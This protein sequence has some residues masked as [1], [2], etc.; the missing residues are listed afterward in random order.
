MSMSI[1]VYMILSLK[2]RAF[3]VS[4]PKVIFLRLN[5]FL[6]SFFLFDHNLAWGGG[7][8]GCTNGTTRQIYLSIYF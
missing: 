4:Q 2:K 1:R 3:T 5:V 6:A 7:M 8:G